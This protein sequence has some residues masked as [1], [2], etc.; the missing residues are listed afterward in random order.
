MFERF[1]AYKNLNESDDFLKGCV[2]LA[3]LTGDEKMLKEANESLRLNKKLKK[4]IRSNRKQAKSYNLN[5][6]NFKEEN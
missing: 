2:I 1:K 3:E 5:Y 4:E 6:R